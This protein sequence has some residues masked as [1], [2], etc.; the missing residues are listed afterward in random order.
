MSTDASGADLGR[1]VR[2]LR[3]ALRLTIEDLAFA[4]DVHPT[5]LSSIER[6]ER[7]PSWNTLCGL[8]DALSLSVPALIEEAEEEAVIARISKAARARL[9]A[10]QD[11]PTQH[12]H[13]AGE[14]SCPVSV[15]RGQ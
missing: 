1:A 7:N 12:P 8:A 10:R 6:G 5:Y 4:A 11:P 2:R 14:I 3:Q 9:R 13:D 15:V